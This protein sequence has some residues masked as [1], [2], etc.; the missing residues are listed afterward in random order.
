MPPH[1]HLLIT[2]AAQLLGVLVL[3]V[4]CVRL[5]EWKSLYCPTRELEATPAL[6]NLTFE[7]IAFVAEDGVVLHGWWLPH[8]NARGTVLH[9]HGNGGNISHRLALAGDLHRLGVNVFLFDYRGYGRSRGWP[10]ERGLYRD[11]Q[12]AYEFVRVQY[13]DAE[14]PPIVLHGQSLGGAVAAQLALAK[15]VRGLI[16]ESAFTSIPD[17]AA[18][19]Y[20]WLPVRLLCASRFDTLDKVRRIACPKLLAH[21]IQ[22]EMIPYTLGRQLFD[23]AAPPKRFCALTGGHNDAGW[24]AS[25]E[26]RR[27]LEE[28]LRETLG[29]ETQPSAGH[30]HLSVG[31]RPP[32]NPGAEPERS[33]PNQTSKESGPVSP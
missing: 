11:A 33:P 19:L 5:L 30:G 25:A 10:S 23:A 20:P 9:C 17:M 29:P 22:D 6:Y 14:N 18:R 28:F 24:A 31:G 12:A 15:P 13:G 8:E 7:D 1:V 2:R 3:A 4:L 26:Y 27:A 21:S 16:L 32:S